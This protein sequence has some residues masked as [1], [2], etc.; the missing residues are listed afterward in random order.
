MPIHLASWPTFYNSNTRGLGALYVP[1]PG[2]ITGTSYN[3]S[4]SALCLLLTYSYGALKKTV[5]LVCLL[6]A[7]ALFLIFRLPYREYIYNNSVY[8]F[9]VADTAPSFFAVIMFVFLQKIRWK[10]L[11]SNI[12]I[13]T[14]AFLGA[15]VYELF[16]Q[17]HIYR[18]TLDWRDT[19]AS[20]LAGIL[21]FFICKYI[22]SR[23]LNLQLN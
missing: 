10:T 8:D 15:S 2:I 17:Q 21:S 1:V 11:F 6:L 7:S 3:R 14:C 18:A 13:C 22:D 19:S 9:Y 4:D 5:Y 23:H 20:F 16:I 12:F